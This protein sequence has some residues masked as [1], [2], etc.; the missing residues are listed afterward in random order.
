[1]HFNWSQIETLLTEAQTTPVTVEFTTKRFAKLFR[2]S[3]Y[4]F[5]RI[6]KTHKELSLTL[7]EEESKE[8]VTT[9][10]FITIYKPVEVYTRKDPTQV[11][12]IQSPTNS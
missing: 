4:N 3:V 8:D 6:K 2:Y 7:I 11:T 10:Y 5:R 9:K 12:N 1:M